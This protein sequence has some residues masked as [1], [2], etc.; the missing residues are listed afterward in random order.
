MT[1]LPQGWSI[2]TLGEVA[3]T[4]LGK[5]LD[6]GRPHGHAQVPYLRNVNVQWDRIDTTG[7]LTME[8]ADEER[9]RFG[10]E[11]GDLLVCEG[12]EI[13]RAAIWRGGVSYIAYQKALHRIRPSCEVDSRYLLHM[14]RH[15]SLSG[16]L[17]KHATGTTI[18]H[19]PQQQLRRIPIPVPPIEEQR[20][21]VDILEDHL[22]RLDAAC[23]DLADAARRLLAFERSALDQITE[24]RAKKRVAL[25]DLVERIEA[26]KSFGGSASPAD[27]DEWGI[28]RVSAMTWGEFRPE[29]NKAVTDPSRV[30]PR[31][32]IKE[33]DVLVSRANTSEY[34]GAPVLV[35]D[36]RPKLLL[37]DKSLR[38]VPKPEYSPEYLVRLLSAPRARGQLSARATGNQDSMRNISQRVLL[39]TTVPWVAAPDRPA[40]VAAC[41]EIDTSA[42]RLRRAIAAADSRAAA[43]RRALLQAAFSGR[44]TRV[45]DDPDR[46]EESIA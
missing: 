38:L 5:M 7:L 10:V 36:T 35:R 21:I 24:G 23:S 18:L 2:R 15:L 44:I 9:D 1:R 32:E 43:A 28:I 3:T 25:S 20:R 8:L 31:Y 40:V 27:P 12:G 16:Q 29:E 46:A 33:G 45:V 34:V 6:R 30:E 11:P 26:G 22:S 41:E 19:L 39:E 17:A 13:G 42:A 37:S 4:A 14:F